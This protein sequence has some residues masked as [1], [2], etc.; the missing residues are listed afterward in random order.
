MQKK[1]ELTTSQNKPKL[2]PMINNKNATSIELIVAMDQ[3]NGI[4]LNG[5]LPWRLTNDMS[6]FK[7]KTSTTKNPNKKNAVL[8]GRKTFESIPKKF[9]PLPNRVNLILTRNKTLSIPNCISSNSLES[10]IQL[11]KKENN[12]IETIFIIGGGEIYKD[13][14]SKNICSKLWV[15]KLY[16]DF[17][18]NTFFPNIPE[19]FKLL[20][21]SKKY[22]EN[23]IEFKFLEYSNTT[24]KATF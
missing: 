22:T 3:N 17:T 23:D 20:N 19:N 15:T 7:E 21:S 11:I 14:I 13:A 5:D 8:M 16:N 4:G 1:H 18:C 6:Y 2:K 24:I 12:Q 9:R 10:A